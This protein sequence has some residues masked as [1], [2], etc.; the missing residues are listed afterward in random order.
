LIMGFSTSGIR[1]LMQYMTRCP[2]NL[3]RL[4]EVAPTGQLVYNA[5]R[6]ACRAFPGLQPGLMKR[7][8]SCRYFWCAHVAVAALSRRVATMRR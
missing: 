4:V 7:L 1:R 8:T 5:E 3:S 6:D 2:F